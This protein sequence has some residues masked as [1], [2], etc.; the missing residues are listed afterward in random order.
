M[1]Y[2]I[3]KFYWSYEQPL[4]EIKCHDRIMC[5]VMDSW[6]YFN[7]YMDNCWMDICCMVKNSLDW[8]ILGIYWQNLW[9]LTFKVQPWSDYQFRLFG[10]NLPGQMCPGQM[11][12]RQMWHGQL[13][14]EQ[15]LIGQIITGFGQSWSESVVKI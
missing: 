9:R 13:L 10:Q 1:T 2:N 5:F 15:L 11:W 7:C 3:G 14:P 8:C 12:Y 6:T 4:I